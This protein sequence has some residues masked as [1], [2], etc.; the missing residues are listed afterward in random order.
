MVIRGSLLRVY[1]DPDQLPRTIKDLVARS[2][3]D[4]GVILTPTHLQA[5]MHS[6]ARTHVWAVAIY[7]IHD[8]RRMLYAHCHYY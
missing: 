7:G 1:A 8:T 4:E 6:R 5:C 2:L 3:G